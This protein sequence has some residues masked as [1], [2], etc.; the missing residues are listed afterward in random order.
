[1]FSK[2]A[3][4]PKQTKSI[5]GSHFLTPSPSSLNEPTKI[6]LKMG[7]VTPQEDNALPDLVFPASPHHHECSSGDDCCVEQ[8]S[9]KYLYK[10]QTSQSNLRE[11]YLDFSYVLK[12]VFN[13]TDKQY[14]QCGECQKQF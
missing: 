6:K 14:C 8:S 1:M 4:T 10:G 9:K 11:R 2:L 5:Y 12:L 13:T 3:N 7:S